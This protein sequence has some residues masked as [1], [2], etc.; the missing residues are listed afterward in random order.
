MFHN[1]FA[2]DAK[3]KNINIKIKSTKT[4]S[5]MNYLH[6]NMFSLFLK[7][8]QNSARLTSMGTFWGQHPCLGSR[9]EKLQE[10]FLQTVQRWESYSCKEQQSRK[11]LNPFW[12]I[13]IRTNYWPS[14]YFIPCWKTEFLLVLQM[15]KSAH[16]TI[17]ILVKKAVWHVN[18]TIFLCS[19]V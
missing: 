14:T 3:K 7:W 6:Q 15:I 18:S 16:C 2:C 13:Q 10:L 1:V 4:N 8:P 5:I 17:T 9:T 19:Y 12:A 11:T